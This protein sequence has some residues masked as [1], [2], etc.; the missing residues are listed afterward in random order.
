MQCSLC[1]LGAAVGT[2]RLPPGP[3]SVALIASVCVPIALATAE[4]MTRE[5]VSC[6]GI[7]LSERERLRLMGFV[8]IATLAC[9][10]YAPLYMCP[11][12]LSACLVGFA[13]EHM[14]ASSRVALWLL[15]LRRARR[16]WASVDVLA[17]HGHAATLRTKRG[18]ILLARAQC[19]LILGAGFADI[20]GS[21]ITYRTHAAAQV[22]GF[23]SRNERVVRR[24]LGR[25]AALRFTS[26]LVWGVVIF[27]PF[28]GRILS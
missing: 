4:A 22:L 16:H 19:D 12:V 13:L 14:L 10:R 17:I 25:L 27:T 5:R 7:A 21:D 24:A 28:S 23:E 15:S 8:G 1:L 9:I 2:L 6:P 20:Q 26:G 18:D 3:L 11:I